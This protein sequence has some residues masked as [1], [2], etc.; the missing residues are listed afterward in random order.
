MG[1]KKGQ[2]KTA[3]EDC[4][5]LGWIPEYAPGSVPTGNTPICI[6]SE[7][8]KET[9]FNPIT[10]EIYEERPYPSERKYKSVYD[11]NFGDCS[12]FERPQKEK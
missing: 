12:K 3:C 10:G 2:K 11:V 7:R 4:V 5:G 9:R 8:D 1:T 6:K